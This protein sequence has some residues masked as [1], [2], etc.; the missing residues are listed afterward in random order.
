M[1]TALYIRVSTKEQA[2]T[3]YS[4][5]GQERK[6]RAFAEAKDLTNIEVYLDDGYSGASLNRPEM[7]RLMRDVNRGNVS[8]VIIYKLDRL[9]RAQKDTMYL[10]EE[11]FNHNNTA[12]ISISE[13][14]DTSTPFGRAA[15]GILSVFAQL[16]RENI[17][18]RMM[19]G[20]EENAKKGLW[21]G[22]GNRF[23]H[24]FGYRRKDKLWHV[25][26]YEAEIVKEVYQLYMNGYGAEKIRN[27]INEKYGYT[28]PDHTRVT[29]ILKNPLYAGKVTH[30]GKVYDGAHEAIVS[31]D[32]YETV[33]IFREKRRVR[34]PRIIDSDYV[35]RGLIKCGK[36]GKNFTSRPVSASRPGR[37]GYYSCH[38]RYAAAKYPEREK[39]LNK[40]HR[41]DDL[42]E[43]VFSELDKLKS[44]KIDYEKHFEDSDT[45][46]V[47]RNKLKDIEEQIERVADLYIA[48][49][50]P[51]KIL[52]EKINKL[53]KEKTSVEKNI[54]NYVP[55]NNLA[56][57]ELNRIQ[58]LDYRK[59]SNADLSN[60]LN[61]LLDRIVIDDNDIKIY[62]NFTL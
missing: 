4:V 44:N 8:T 56:A 48:G 7:Q 53:N 25:E 24:T 52:N 43:L 38:G 36:C 58:D 39:C 19:M 20:K 59:L 33:Q 17:K 41:K 6:L 16:E 23:G 10:I 9:S 15:I 62:Y 29:S 31:E 42:H 49:N 30:S 14:F 3:G 46:A 61:I 60:L 1:K 13:S 11:V 21:N 28:F 22:G 27:L 35:L 18:E 5:I 55:K 54:K 51:E 32:L 2:E 45:I 26:P 47:F 37:K 12:L 40:N 34:T 57:K 50:I